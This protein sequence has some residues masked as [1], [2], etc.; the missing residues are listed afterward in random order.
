[1]QVFGPVIGA[2]LV[3]KAIAHNELLAVVR[4]DHYAR[5]LRIVV[6]HG[7]SRRRRAH[8]LEQPRLGACVGLHAAVVVKM[9]LREIGE[10]RHIHRQTPHALLLERMRAH[11]HHG[12]RA[13]GAYAFGKQRENVAAF[14]RGVLA[15]QHA[16][17]NARFHGAQQHTLAAYAREHLL[18]QE[19]GRGLAIGAGHGA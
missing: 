6:D 16:V 8:A 2:G 4:I 13:A 9:V 3:L 14:R 10:D 1:M 17:S 7:N 18:Q 19:R 11:L 5:V 12:F 15:R